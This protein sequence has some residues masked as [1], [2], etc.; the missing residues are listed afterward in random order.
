MAKWTE[1]EEVRQKEE[2]EKTSRWWMIYHLWGGIFLKAYVDV[3]GLSK[4]VLGAPSGS[5]LFL[6]LAMPFP[7]SC[8]LSGRWRLATFYQKV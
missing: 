1:G 4:F 5:A 8:L 6:R 3:S 2:G 7:L